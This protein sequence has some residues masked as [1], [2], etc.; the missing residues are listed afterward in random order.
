NGR[1]SRLRPD[2]LACLRVAL[3]CVR[4]ERADHRRIGEYLTYVRPVPPRSLALP[5]APRFPRV[6][7]EPARDAVLSYA[8]VCELGYLCAHSG[9]FGKCLDLLGVGVRAQP[10]RQLP[11]VCLC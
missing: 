6:L 8:F 4:R 10:S 3:C 2:Q 9:S 11:C 7:V 1:L 5:S